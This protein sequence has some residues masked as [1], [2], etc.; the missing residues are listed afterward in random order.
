MP[1]T[2][3]LSFE[4]ERCW[5]LV[6][7]HRGRIWHARRVKPRAGEPASVAFD[8]PWVLAREERRGDVLG[9][10][11]THPVGRPRPSRRDVR[12]MRGWTSAFGKPLLCVIESPVGLAAFR[13]DDDRSD[14]V[15]L[16]VIERFPRGVV[17]A[18]DAR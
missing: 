7:A 12:T 13:F 4:I 17:I 14:G 1:R 8:G 11:H 3:R 9:F 15:I 6:G 16:G 10:F 18:V 2:S 5:T